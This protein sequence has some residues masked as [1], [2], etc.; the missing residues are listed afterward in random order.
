MASR[1]TVG[2]NERR[3]FKPGA[4]KTEHF[5]DCPTCPE[6]V[7]VPA[8][9]FTMGSP[10]NEPEREGL[11][12]Q[13]LVSIAAPFA[14]GRFAVTFDEWDSCVADGGCNGY[15]PGDEGW[16][17]GKHP[18][19][20]VNWYDA[21]AY[22]T[23]LSRKT[24]KTYRLLSEGER[25]YVTRAGTMT[26]FWWGTSITP[27]QANYDGSVD[28]YKGGGSKGEYPKQAVSVDSFVA[29]P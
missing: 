28:P 27:T 14:V 26:P 1:F 8:G 24:G 6:M 29:N 18:V 20:N 22:T 13:V 19:I 10:A 12:K 23:W 9:S 21:K 4:G 7:V 25:E 15:K 2:L 11:E 16:G 5:Q 3:C 17:R